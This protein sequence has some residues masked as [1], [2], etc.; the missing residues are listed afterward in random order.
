MVVGASV[1]HLPAQGRF[2]SPTLS[3]GHVPGL[4]T[5]VVLLKGGGRAPAL[6]GHQPPSPHW[7]C[8]VEVA[9]RLSPGEAPDR[10]EPVFQEARLRAFQNGCEGQG[11]RDDPVPAECCAAGTGVYVWG[12]PSS[13]L[14]LQSFCFFL[15][16]PL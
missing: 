14:R 5:V 10:L 4:R 1:S 3:A 13:M 9:R 16:G 7:V 11:T 15:I 12:C 2:P 8:C 6:V